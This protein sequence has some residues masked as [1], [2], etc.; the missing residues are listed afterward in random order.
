LLTYFV[1]TT[2]SAEQLVATFIISFV[3]VILWISYD[4]V[5]TQ[6]STEDE[7]KKLNDKY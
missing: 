7:L 4:L 3:V 5:K 1:F 2:L 6:I